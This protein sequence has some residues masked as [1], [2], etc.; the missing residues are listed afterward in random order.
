MGKRVPTIY[1]K[2]TR[3]RFFIQFLVI[4]HL[5]I[6]LGC[7]WFTVWGELTCQWPYFLLWKFMHYAGPP[8]ALSAVCKFKNIGLMLFALIFYGLL[9]V[10]D[11]VWVS[12]AAITVWVP[13]VG[14]CASNFVV[15]MVAFW[16]TF[17]L[18]FLELLIAYSIFTLR[19]SLLNYSSPCGGVS[20][21]S[22]DCRPKIVTRVNTGNGAIAFTNSQISSSISDSVPDLVGDSFDPTI[23]H[24]IPNN[25]LFSIEGRIFDQEAFRSR[26]PI[27]QKRRTRRRRNKNQSS[28]KGKST[29]V[30]QL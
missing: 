19:C 2:V 6:L 3:E 28:A 21:D 26:R 4:L 20:L 30:V 18:I 23:V 29:F 11:V 15:F 17:G 7:I 16:I 10:V 14:I 24:G 22:L 27:S 12:I 13:C 25:G 5:I 1:E 9:A 8:L